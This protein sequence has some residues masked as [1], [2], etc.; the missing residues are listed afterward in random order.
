MI[1][2]SLGSK[3]QRAPFLRTHDS[4]ERKKLYH[5]KK[6]KSPSQRR[7]SE[8]IFVRF[9]HFRRRPQSSVSSCGVLQTNWD[10]RASAAHQTNCIIFNFEKSVLFRAFP[11]YTRRLLWGAGAITS[12]NICGKNLRISSLTRSRRGSENLTSTI[13]EGWTEQI[14]F[15]SK[16]QELKWKWK[17]ERFHTDYLWLELSF[18]F[19]CLVD[20]F[21]SLS[22]NDTLPRN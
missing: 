7:S 20:V 18:S 12:T 10:L 14:H 8:R 1:S 22:S 11:T 17:R 4:V 16:I 6:E 13:S 3:Q 5:K 9:F 19:V 15:K 21:I 2:L